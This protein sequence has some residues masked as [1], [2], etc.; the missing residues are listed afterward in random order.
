MRAQAHTYARSS[1]TC[2][3]HAQ[4]L[5]HAVLALA[6]AQDA[7]SPPGCRAQP[8]RWQGF[9]GWR[10]HWRAAPSPGAANPRDGAEAFGRPQPGHSWHAPRLFHFLQPEVLPAPLCTV[11]VKGAAAR[12]RCGTRNIIHFGNNQA[13]HGW[14]VRYRHLAARRLCV[15]H[16]GHA[17]VVVAIWG[18][19]GGGGWEGREGTGTGTRPLRRAG[20]RKR[21]NCNSNNPLVQP[22]RA[23]GSQGT[24]RELRRGVE[25]VG[26]PSGH[27]TRLDRYVAALATADD[28]SKLLQNTMRQSTT[29]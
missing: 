1:C 11:L 18:Q 9:T 14:A 8:T 24:P 12:A 21:T 22:A 13:G 17:G 20:F 26:R 29:Q 15:W 4:Q 19:E 23:E 10:Q 28:G 7:S 2:S 6:V 16:R 5:P 25:A 27:L 3:H